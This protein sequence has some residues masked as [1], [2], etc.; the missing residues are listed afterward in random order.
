MNSGTISRQ[1]MGM[2]LEQGK[3]KVLFHIIDILIV[4]W[5]NDGNCTAPLSRHLILTH[6]FAQNKDNCDMIC[7]KCGQ[8]IIGKAMKVI[9]IIN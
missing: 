7:G 9:K 8:N 4:N 2:E 5:N 3:G 6:N 1:E